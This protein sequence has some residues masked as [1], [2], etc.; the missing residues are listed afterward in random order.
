MRK[1]DIEKIKAYAFSMLMTI[2][3]YGAFVVADACSITGR[4]NYLGMTAADADKMFASHLVVGGVVAVSIFAFVAMMID[5]VL[6]IEEKE[7]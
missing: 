1:I 2:I 5:K 7:E 3:G 6:F 4:V